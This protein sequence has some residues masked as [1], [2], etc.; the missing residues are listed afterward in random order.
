MSVPRSAPRLLAAAF[1]LY[2][3]YPVLFL[4]LAAGVIVPYELIVLAATGTGAFS[5]SSLSFGTEQL[6]ELADLALVGPLVS[7]LHVHA[8]AEVKRDREPRIG[9]VAL[10]GLRVL[11]VVAAATIIS[12]LGMTL[13]L[14]LLVVPGIVLMLR[15]AVVAQTAAI[16]HEGWL[17]A[18]RR[19]RRLTEGNY[20]HVFA[21][22]I[23][24]GVITIIPAIA[25]SIAFGH[26][27]TGAA[28]FLSGLAIHVI[29]ASF[30]ALATALLYY[31]LLVRWEGAA[32]AVATAVEAGARPTGTQ[33]RPTETRQASFDP[34]AYSDLDRPK[35]WYVDPAAPDRMRYWGGSEQ[36]GWS[37]STRTP[38]KIR[39]AWRAEDTDMVPR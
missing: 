13:G 6:L 7:A 28:S 3:R 1:E 11:P 20:R 39:L 8:V 14:L 34:R 18:L 15:W 10:Q 29:M 35:G 26:H 27:D 23:L 32:A 4:V 9:S 33:Q 31:D 37:R 24:V 36:P 38:R 2:R 12:W 16:K 19:S 25:G 21:F 5:R 30:A 17:P 22:L